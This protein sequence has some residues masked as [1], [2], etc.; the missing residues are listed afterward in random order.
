MTHS[1]NHQPDSL[2]IKL[3]RSEEKYNKLFEYS[4]FG[5]AMINH[6]T[7]AFHEVNRSLLEMTGYTKE[8]FLQLSFWDI[9]PPQYLAQEEQQKLDLEATGRFGPNEKE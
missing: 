5:M 7:G 6:H 2:D 9:T 3:S 4:P 1:E 8:E